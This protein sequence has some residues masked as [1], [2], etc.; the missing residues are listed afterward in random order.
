M[1]AVL[2]LFSAQAC[3]EVLEET[4]PSTAISDQVALNDPGAVRAIRANMYSRMQS[5]TFTT[6]MMIG[7]ESLADNLANRD[8]SSRFQSLHLNNLRAGLNDGGAYNDVYN[9]IQEANVL[10]EAIPDGIIPDDERSRIRGEALALRAYAMHYHVRVMGYDP[11]APDPNT[12]R[13]WDLG[14]VLRTDPVLGLSDADERPRSSVADVYTQIVADLQESITLLD[15]NG[16]TDNRFVTADFA[17]GILARVQL[18]NG[19]YTEAATQ[20]AAARAGVTGAALATPAQVPTM[21]NE[22]IGPNPEAIFLVVINPATESQGVNNSLAAYTANQWVAQVP[23][24]D[25]I[26]LYDPADARNAWFSACDNEGTA[27]DTDDP[28]DAIPGCLANV[29]LNKWNG[30]LTNFTDDVPVL[31][32]SE[33][34]L[35]EA[36]A[37]LNSTGAAAAIPLL[38]Q[39]RA[40]RGLA[41]YAGSTAPADV[42]NE[43]LDERRREFIGEGHR[44]FDLK[45]LGRTITKGNPGLGDRPLVAVPFTDVRILDDY[46]V[47]EL[48]DN[49]ELVQNPGY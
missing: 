35:I 5:F 34:L 25:V 46:L 26:S 15:A 39:L 41:A 32:V 21:F 14:I 19:N 27:P 30:E 3:T 17:R 10:A 8:G 18:Y 11:T 33:L 2:V 40:A 47:D 6:R 37:R 23:T 22:T 43:I 44:F 4:E 1:I 31:R 7:P 38:D 13:N 28:A 36:E 20:A 9:L 42:L 48:E 29:E 24:N 45:R 49:D 12:S 16:G